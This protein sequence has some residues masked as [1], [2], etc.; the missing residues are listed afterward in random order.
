[1]TKH[2][3]TTAE[4]NIIE[5][6]DEERRFL[7]SI[8]ARSASL[9]VYLRIGDVG[10]ADYI[11]AYRGTANVELVIPRGRPVFTWTSAG[12]ATMCTIRI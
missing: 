9:V 7:F 1:M 12:T 4:L 5:S 11:F 2:S 8:G 6:E 10:D 3:L